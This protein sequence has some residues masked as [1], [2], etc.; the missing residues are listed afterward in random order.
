MPELT[1]EFY[2]NAFFKASQFRL[3]N[4]DETSKWT[5]EL[6][7]DLI[8]KPA[9]AFLGFQQPQFDINLQIGKLYQAAFGGAMPDE[10]ML[11]WGEAYR[12]GVSL[13]QMASSFL[14]SER[15][16]TEFAN[17]GRSIEVFLQTRYQELTGQAI[18]PALLQTGLQLYYSGSITEAQLLLELSKYADDHLVTLGLLEQAIYPDGTSSLALEGYSSDTR[19]AISEL[20]VEKEKSEVPDAADTQGFLEKDGVLSYSG[21]EELASV[22]ID[23]SKQLITIDD[24]TAGLIEGDLTNVVDIDLELAPIQAFD[25]KGNDTDNQIMLPDQGGRIALSSGEDFVELNAG[26][27]VIEFPVSIGANDLDVI[28]NFERGTGGDQ[29]DFSSFLDV[30]NATAATTAIDSQSTGEQAWQNGDVLVVSG[31]GLNTA[32]SISG[33]FGTGQALA[34]PTSSGKLVLLTA[35]IVGDASVWYVTNQLT[36]SSVTSDEITHAAELVGINNLSL[37]GFSS[38]NFS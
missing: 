10:Q 12:N 35:D 36:P 17:A 15:F 7:N 26:Q 24:A 16:A 4:Q 1:N 6:S 9:L 14:N 23:L 29:L 18:D 22:E 25:V 37:L 20:L 3:P 27:D 13:E 33:L 34:D 8:S 11:V 21:D 31:Y 19:L 28:Q 5:D 38:D 32:S 30:V 2:V